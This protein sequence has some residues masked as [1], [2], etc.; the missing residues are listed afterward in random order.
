MIIKAI[1][2]ISVVALFALYFNLQSIHTKNMLGH[3]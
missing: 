3:D 1:A 2:I